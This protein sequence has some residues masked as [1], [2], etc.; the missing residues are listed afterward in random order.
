MKK[1]YAIVENVN[2]VMLIIQ[3]SMITKQK[4]ILA[5]DVMVQGVLSARSNY[6]SRT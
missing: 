2:I 3:V 4:S 5:L 1:Y 6:E